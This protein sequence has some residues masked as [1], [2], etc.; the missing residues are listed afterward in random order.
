VADVLLRAGP[1]VD[2]L[3]SDGCIGTVILCTHGDVAST[4]LCASLD[5]PLEQHREVGAL[6]TGVLHPL[7]VRIG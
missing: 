7:G 2:E 1:V 3:T 5:V 4:L 6:H